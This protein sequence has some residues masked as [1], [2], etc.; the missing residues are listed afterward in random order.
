MINCNVVFTNS[1]ENKVNDCFSEWDFPRYSSPEVGLIANIDDEFTQQHFNSD[2]NNKNVCAIEFMLPRNPYEQPTYMLQIPI[3]VSEAIR[4][5]L[6]I[7]TVLETDDFGKTTYLLAIDAN[8]GKQRTPHDCAKNVQFKFRRGSSSENLESELKQLKSSD[9]FDEEQQERGNELIG[10]WGVFLEIEEEAAKKRRFE[11]DYGDFRIVGDNPKKGR[12][13]ITLE[14]FSDRPLPRT[15]SKVRI[16]KEDQ[17]KRHVVEAEILKIFNTSSPSLKLEIYGN[18]KDKTEYLEK[19]PKT[20]IIEFKDAG[21][22]VECRRQ[23]ESIAKLVQGDFHIQSL[24]Q[25]LFAEKSTDVVG[26]KDFEMPETSSELKLLEE[27]INDEQKKAVLLGLH[28]PDVALIQGPPGTGKTTVIAEL[29]YQFALQGKKVLVASQ[30][31]LAVDNAL[32]RLGESTEVFAIRLAPDL[33]KLEPEGLDFV[34]DRAI[35]RWL[36]GHIKPATKERNLLEMCLNYETLVN[37]INMEDQ[38]DWFAGEPHGSF[39][40]E[41]IDAIE[42]WL[43]NPEPYANCLFNSVAQFSKLWKTHVSQHLKKIPNK[44]AAFK[45]LEVRDEM[46]GLK[47]E[48]CVDKLENI[49]SRLNDLP[50]LLEDQKKKTAVISS[51]NTEIFNNSKHAE[52][53]KIMFDDLASSNNIRTKGCHKHI[54]LLQRYMDICKNPSFSNKL[55]TRLFDLLSST[56]FFSTYPQSKVERVIS[57]QM[58]SEEVLDSHDDE[59][60]EEDL[61]HFISSME[62]KLSCVSFFKKVPI[63]NRIYR[64][65]MNHVRDNLILA[66]RPNYG[67]LNRYI[68]KRIHSVL[69][70]FGHQND[71]LQ[72]KLYRASKK[73]KESDEATN[74]V[75]VMLKDLGIANFDLKDFN[76]IHDEQKYRLYLAQNKESIESLLKE[77]EKKCLDL[78]HC[79][80]ARWKVARLLESFGSYSHMNVKDALDSV[81]VKQLDESKTATA[82]KQIEVIDSWIASCRD[83]EKAISPVMRNR[84]DRMANVIGVTCSYAGSKAFADRFTHNEFDCVIVDE[85]STATPTQLL[86][87][88]LWGKKIILVGDHKQLPPFLNTDKDF[89]QVAEEHNYDGKEIIESLQGSP[90]KQRFEEFENDPDPSINS[91]C[92][93]LKAQYRMHPD[94]MAGINKFYDGE[95]RVGF[96]NMAQVR[97]H[98]LSHIPWIGSEDSHVIWVDVPET[99]EYASKQPQGSYSW[100][101]DGQ[102]LLCA[103]IMKQLCN[104]ENGANPEDVGLIMPYAG[105]VRAYK[106]LSQNLALPDNL[107]CSSIDRF[108]GM[109]RE[110]LVVDLVHNQNRPPTRFLDSHERINVAFSRGRSLLVIVGSYKCFIKYYKDS[111]YSDFYD[112]ASK[113]GLVLTPEKIYA[114]D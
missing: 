17:R 35:R 113:R 48:L 10:K 55:D 64:W 41:E 12:F 75:Y 18:K 57:Q 78:I 43:S 29:C 39:A 106:G 3:K 1:A 90:F 7:R 38:S 51:I 28:T 99:S 72:T 49:I 14:G 88:C 31:N 15:G 54:D 86:M 27:N 92:I 42:G 24:Q 70:E 103:T 45:P 62:F 104:P 69:E 97:E 47:Q 25:V 102:A 84:F 112:I 77:W 114:A 53:L 4:K 21:T 32:S 109:E 105:Q 73:L 16:Y 37:E 85:V 56:Y 83:G 63:F 6:Y 44:F 81:G 94:I 60:L 36:R 33:G 71:R 93:M 46:H 23:R 108:Q 58:A 52:S 9:D 87:P 19:I 68:Q 8:P 22:E 91:R 107:R 111:P 65:M 98:K 59:G 79:I 13:K 30:T 110:Y 2:E 80:S 11:D 66:M 76:E 82:G 95:L 40:E 74:G 96:E 20:G 34:E 100:K 50:T 26:L 101:N 67:K 5:T 89:E 61:Y